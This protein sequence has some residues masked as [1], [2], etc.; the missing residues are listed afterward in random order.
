LVLLAF[1]LLGIVSGGTSGETRQGLVELSLAIDGIEG[2]RFAS[3]RV[4]FIL[5]YILHHGETL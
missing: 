4:L 3:L 1:V 2:M 5:I